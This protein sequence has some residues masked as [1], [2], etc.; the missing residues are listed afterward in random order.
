MSS[1]LAL[2]TLHADVATSAGASSD[3]GDGKAMSGQL[4]AEERHVACSSGTMREATPDP[5]GVGIL[6]S[7]GIGATGELRLDRVGT[8]VEIRIVRTPGDDSG[9]ERSARRRRGWFRCLVVGH[10]SNADLATLA[11]VALLHPRF[12][13]RWL[14]QRF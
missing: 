12:S 8:V 5:R 3:I 4:V 13:L 9:Q 2:W 1:V 11:I 10:P 14:I 7:V 6:A